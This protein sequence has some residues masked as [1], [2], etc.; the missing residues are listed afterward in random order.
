[1]NDNEEKELTIS[2]NLKEVYEY[3]NSEDF[4]N[5]VFSTT[6]MPN[7]FFI[8]SLLNKTLLYMATDAQE[9]TQEKIDVE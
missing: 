6:S 9:N 1:M 8:T 7:A 5:Y 3:V 4:M 2:V